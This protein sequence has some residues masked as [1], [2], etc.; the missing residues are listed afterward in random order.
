MKVTTFVSISDSLLPPTSR[1]LFYF[2]EDRRSTKLMLIISKEPRVHTHLEG[3][4]KPSKVCHKA[5]SKTHDTR[6][7]PPWTTHDSHHPTIQ[8]Q[9][10]SYLQELLH[11]TLFIAITMFCGTDNILHNIVNPAR[12]CYGFE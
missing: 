4:Q 7:L 3:R 8:G 9:P 12:R 10:P 6:I 11:I 2:Y 5:T 1:K